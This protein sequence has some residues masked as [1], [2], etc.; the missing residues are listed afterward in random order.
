[1]QRFFACQSFLAVISALLLTACGGGAS[2]PPP[3]PPA[4]HFSVTAP[5]SVNAGTA[6]NLTI[7]ALDASTNVVAGYSGTVHFTSTDIQA[8]L[9]ANSALANGTATLSAT[10]KSPG[11][12]T[13]TGTDTA[14]PSITGTSSSIKIAVAASRFQITGPLA[15]ARLLHTA[16]LL[17]TGAVLIAGG[18]DRTVVLSSTEIFDP[19]SGLFTP[20]GDMNA[21]RDWHT[22]T[23][24]TDGSVLITG[25]GDF[26]SP[27]F[28]SAELYT[29]STGTFTATGRMVTREARIR[30]LCFLAARCSSPEDGMSPVMCS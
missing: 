10:L 24:L 19:A 8:V 26:T 13:I 15:T 5:A 1:M 30:R 17:A 11:G 2:S 18:T 6:F 21:A 14:A 7:T 22:A 4:T 25:G 12:Q 3:P 28:S 20:S 9:P 27:S 23:L 29:P 16:T